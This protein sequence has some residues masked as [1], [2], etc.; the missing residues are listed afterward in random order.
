MTAEDAGAY[1]RHDR[2]QFS[3]VYGN[4]IVFDAYPCILLGFHYFT[5]LVQKKEH[6]EEEHNI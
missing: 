5:Y 3:N 1:A 2:S 4:I 6:L